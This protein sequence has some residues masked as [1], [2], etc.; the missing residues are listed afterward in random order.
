[1]GEWVEAWDDDDL[2]RRGRAFDSVFEAL[3]VFHEAPP[4]VPETLTA[5]S[6]SV[7]SFYPNRLFVSYGLFM[8]ARGD[9]DV[10]AD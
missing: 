9:L 6:G 4:A 5:C 7:P 1:M 2:D 10:A 3:D 8:Q